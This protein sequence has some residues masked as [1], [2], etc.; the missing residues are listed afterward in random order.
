MTQS[1]ES[2]PGIKKAALLIAY[3]NGMINR[4]NSEEQ[5]LESR[6][7]I[8]GADGVYYEDLQKIDEFL[9]GLEQGQIEDL[10]FGE[11]E[12]QNIVVALWQFPDISMSGFLND[13]FEG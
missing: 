11:E 6:D 2:F 10:C 13:L 4:F 8:I 5:F 1:M 12:D 9:Q 3:D 7:V